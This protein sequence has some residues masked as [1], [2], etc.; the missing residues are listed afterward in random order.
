MTK[1]LNPTSCE[2]SN[3]FLKIRTK[4]CYSY[5]LPT[6]PIAF[7]ARQ[8]YKYASLRNNNYGLKFVHQS[9]RLEQILPFPYIIGTME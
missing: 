6:I 4:V 1:L 2:A 3:S 5:N 8:L 7:S 9:L